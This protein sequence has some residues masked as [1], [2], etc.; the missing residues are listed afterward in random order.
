MIPE[1]DAVVA[2]TADTGNMQGELNAI[3]EKL[4]PGFEGEPL[5]EDATG[6]EKVKQVISR[7][8]AHPANKSK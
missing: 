7:L 5:P 1:K 6:Q 8:E 3:W 4:L 2:I